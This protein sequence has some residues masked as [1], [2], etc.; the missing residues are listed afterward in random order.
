MVMD[1]FIRVFGRAK[2]VVIGM[3]HVRA[4][5][6][7]FNYP[8]FALYWFNFVLSRPIMLVVNRY[9]LCSRSL[10]QRTDRM[11]HCSQVHRDLA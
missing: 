7:I 8:I 1:R 5:P 4:L 10:F 9:A 2:D 11:L 3:V 6:G